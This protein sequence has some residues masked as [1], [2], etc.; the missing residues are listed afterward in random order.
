MARYKL[1]EG[2][3]LRPFGVNSKLDNSNLTDSIAVLLIKKGRASK[4]DFIIATPKRT[5]Q[6]Q[7]K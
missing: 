2:V 3:I 7:Q 6:K 5:K 1:K 4:E